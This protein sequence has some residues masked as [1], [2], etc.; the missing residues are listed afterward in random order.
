MPTSAWHYISPILQRV[1]ELHQH[2]PIRRVLDVGV[3]SGKWGFLTREVVD[4]YA[5][6]VYFKQDWRL[7]L[8]GI[9]AF[10]RYRTSIHDHVYDQ[11]YWGDAIEILRGS[12]LAAETFDVIFAMEVIEHIEKSAGEWLLKRLVGQAE[13]AVV[14]SFPPE[15]DSEGHHIFEQGST[16]GNPYE[17]HKSIWTVKDLASFEYD[18]IAPLCYLVHGKAVGVTVIAEQRSSVRER[19][20]RLLQGEGSFVDYRLPRVTAEIEIQVL[21]HP[22]SASLAIT[23]ASGTDAQIIDLFADE[24]VVATTRVRFARPTNEFR[25]ELKGNPKSQGHE[26]WIHSVRVL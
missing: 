7:R 9:E 5:N 15:V 24:A 10:E 13:R 17:A 1:Y 18:E 16:H 2:R 20:V 19:G 11:I 23:S 22:W 3:G 8:V 12:D 6:C 26:A 21:R 14:L 4:F 25:A